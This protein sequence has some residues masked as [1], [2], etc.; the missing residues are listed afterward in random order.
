MM[1]NCKAIETNIV[2]LCS[3]YLRDMREIFSGCESM[4]YLDFRKHR[5]LFNYTEKENGLYNCLAM[6]Q[7][8]IGQFYDTARNA[9]I[10]GYSIKHLSDAS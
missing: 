9:E 4:T 8:D 2:L 7:M 1:M 6:Q 10:E 5:T 3:N